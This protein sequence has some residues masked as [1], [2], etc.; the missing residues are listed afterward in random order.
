MKNFMFAVFAVVAM[1]GCSSFAGPPRE[2]VVVGLADA[3]VP[4]TD[5]GP[6]LPIDSGHAALD[7]GTIEMPREIDAGPPLGEAPA[8]GDQCDPDRSRGETYDCRLDG[9][10][11]A[12]LVCLGSGVWHCVPDTGAICVPVPVTDAG[13]DAGPA[14]VDA[15]SPAVD[16]GHDAGPIAV[17]AGPAVMATDA[18]PMDFCVAGSFVG[19]WLSLGCPGHIDCNVA[20]GRYDSAC[21]PFAEFECLTATR[22]AGTDAGPPPVVDAG[23]DAGSDLGTDAGSDAGPAPTPDAGSLY[24]PTDYL[25]M[26]IGAATTHAEVLVW[27]PEGGVPD[28]RL[29][30]S[31]VWR[32]SRRSTTLT[33]PMSELTPGPYNSTVFCQR[34]TTDPTAASSE[35]SWDGYASPIVSAG[36]LGTPVSTVRFLEVS[37]GG[38]PALANTFYCY[39]T[40]VRGLRRIQVQVVDP[41]VSLPRSC[42]G[43]TGTP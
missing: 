39:S 40:D 24:T 29:H 21:F 18:G 9:C 17:D 15:G 26:R 33:I 2:D 13:T 4:A 23:Y 22:D 25:R 11:R 41:S 12:Y 7:A 43:S 1:M 36:T 8:S 31:S 37:I 6:A 34:D 28:I 35:P 16:A 19:C 30:N 14:A 27:C 42:S 3:A 5:G 10:D 32:T 38:R 20:N